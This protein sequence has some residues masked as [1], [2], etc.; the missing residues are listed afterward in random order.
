M[1]GVETRLCLS[2]QGQCAMANIDPKVNATRR[3]SQPHGELYRFREV[4]TLDRS[5]LCS[6]ARHAVSSAPTFVAS[7]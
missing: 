2:I 4:C 5:S 1:N 6:A 3:E 7:V